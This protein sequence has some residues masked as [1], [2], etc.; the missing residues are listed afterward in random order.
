MEKN[1]DKMGNTEDTTTL[2]IAP[3]EKSLSRLNIS[4]N[5]V[6]LKGISWLSEHFKD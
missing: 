5:S 3:K 1:S 6:M 4:R 2:V